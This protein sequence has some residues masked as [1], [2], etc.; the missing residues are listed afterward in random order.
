MKNLKK[1]KLEQKYH[2]LISEPKIAMLSL[3]QIML[4]IEA[5]HNCLLTMMEQIEQR[6][7]GEHYANHNDMQDMII[8][9]W[10]L[11]IIQDLLKHIDVDWNK[12]KDAM[13]SIVSNNIQHNIN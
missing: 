10:K 3:M 5:N 6:K 8:F 9:R 11:E 1:I 7:N 13:A 12:Y 4:A 2:Q